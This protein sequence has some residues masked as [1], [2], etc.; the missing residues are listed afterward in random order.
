VIFA[1]GT[2]ID[3]STSELSCDGPLREPF[4]VYCQV[5][6]FFMWFPFPVDVSYVLAKVFKILSYLVL[7]Y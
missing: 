7:E 3:G 2:F 4:A 5:R 1:D 6:A